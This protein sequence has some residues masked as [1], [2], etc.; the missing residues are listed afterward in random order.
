MKHTNY[1]IED[2]MRD[3]I[4]GL[5]SLRAVASMLVVIDHIITQLLYYKTYGE[6]Y[7][8]I[9][10]NIKILGDMGVYVFFI[11]SGY[12]MLFSTQKNGDHMTQ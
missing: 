9:L 5:Q 4:D 11:L 1:I 7:D 12:I 6:V 2:Y 3:R 8:K 10:G